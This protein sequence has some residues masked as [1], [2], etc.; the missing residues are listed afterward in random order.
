MV[1]HLA[2]IAVRPIIPRIPRIL[3]CAACAALLAL[4]GCGHRGPLYLPGKPGDPAYDR[5][6]K[7]E[8]PPKPA[9]SP[10]DDR[11]VNQTRS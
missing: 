2:V 9:P 4:A 11:T 1:L 6:H 8:T 10:D 7:G 3:L 5:E